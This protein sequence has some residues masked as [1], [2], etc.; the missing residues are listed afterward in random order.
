MT[1]KP[2]EVLVQEG[3]AHTQI[4]P[5]LGQD[6]PFFAETPPFFAQTPPS[7]TPLT[8][9]VWAENGGGLGKI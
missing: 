8:C 5:I 2:E 4:P 6:P 9:G 1:R 3:V 7:K